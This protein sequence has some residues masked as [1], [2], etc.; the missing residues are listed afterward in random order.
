MLKFKRISLVISEKK[1][2]VLGFFTLWFALAMLQS[3][4][5]PLSGEEAYY[6]LFSESLDWGYLDHPPAVAFFAH[7]GYVLFGNELGVRLLSTLLSTITLVLLLDLVGRRHFRTFIFASLGLLAVHAGSFLVKTDV[8][9]LFFEVLFFWFYKKYLKQE[10]WTAI[11]GLAIAIA[12]MFLSKYHGVLVVLFTVASNFRLLQKRSFWLIV[13]LTAILMLPHL[14]WLI[15]HDFSSIRFH[16]QGR[17]DISFK[18]SNVIG[19]IISQPLVLGP[20]VSIPMGIALFKRGYADLFSKALLFVLV[21][22]LIFFFIQSFR[23]FIHK[24]WTSIALVPL[25]VLT[26]EVLHSDNKLSFYLRRLSR[27]TII[28]LVLFRLYLIVDYVPDSLKGKTEPLHDWDKWAQSVNALSGGMPVVFINSYEN[29]SRYQFYTGLPAHTLST[30]Y[31]N[32]TQFDQWGYED[33]FRN[34][35]ALVIHHKRNQQGF[36]TVDAPNSAQIHYKRVRNFNTLSKLWVEVNQIETVNQGGRITANL[37]ISNPYPFD[38]ESSEN[39][40]VRLKLFTLKGERVLSEHLISSEFNLAAHSE[41]VETISVAIGQL[42]ENTQLR[43]GIE[44]GDLPA[45]INSH[46]I[47]L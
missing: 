1:H 36:Q 21:G 28:V 44:V 41:R 6:W 10:D 14:L 8:P 3:A 35:S 9:L 13:L 23:V 42:D 18:W 11:V 25:L 31:F 38:I 40:A 46:R 33:Y 26:V 17:A 24:H 39:S 2:I 19:Y 32:N 20:L 4:F 29:A 15:E 16:L 45:T 22:V 37:T 5:M 7:L 12:G 27:I 30:Y 47:H 34:R 43:F